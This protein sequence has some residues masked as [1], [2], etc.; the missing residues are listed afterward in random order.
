MKNI[1]YAFG[2]NSKQHAVQYKVYI[3][4]NVYICAFP[5]FKPMLYYGVI[6]GQRYINI[7]DK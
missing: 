6:Q 7:H 3:L 5:E 1:S 2:I 4:S